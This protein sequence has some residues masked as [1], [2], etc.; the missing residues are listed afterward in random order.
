[1]NKDSEDRGVGLDN[2]RYE[3]K[4]KALHTGAAMIGRV[5]STNDLYNTILQ[6]MIEVLGYPRSGLGIPDEDQ[7]HFIVTMHE[8]PNGPN[9]SIPM[10]VP[11]IPSRAYREKKTQIVNDVRLDPDYFERPQGSQ[12]GQTVLS[13]SLIHI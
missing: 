6:T 8:I 1:M 4:I 5:S 3:E 10:D 13:L 11:S 9:F 2:V 12:S 7:M